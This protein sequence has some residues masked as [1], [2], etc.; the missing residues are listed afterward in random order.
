MANRIIRVGYESDKGVTFAFGLNEEVFDQGAVGG[1]ALTAN[2]NH[3]P[4]PQQMKPR[5]AVCYNTA[6]SHRYVPLLSA[7]A[8]LATPG[9]SITLEDSD[10]AA[11]TYTCD[12]VL[13]E[14]YRSRRQQNNV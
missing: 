2:S 11:S 8:P 10:G 12:R 13:G 5:R 9:A 1:V 14:E 4:F 7:A 6:G 3:Y